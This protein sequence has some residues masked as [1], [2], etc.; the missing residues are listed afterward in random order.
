MQVENK[1]FGVKARTSAFGLCPED[2][3]THDSQ[4]P[5]VW[6]V[7]VPTRANGVTLGLPLQD[8]RTRCALRSAV[9]IFHSA[10]RNL[11]W[12]IKMDPALNLNARVER[13]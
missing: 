11:H 5:W 9:I 6:T 12:T 10:K 1:C 8:A 4:R 13:I 3:I 2:S 7:K